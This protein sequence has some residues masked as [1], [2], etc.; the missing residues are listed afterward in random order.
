MDDQKKIEEGVI[1]KVQEVVDK[2]REQLK[3]VQCPEHGQALEKLDFNREEGR[4][5]IETCCKEGE[6][7]V[8]TAINNLG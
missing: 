6:K 4:F 7:L 5:K 2:A 3:Q 1:D 8:N